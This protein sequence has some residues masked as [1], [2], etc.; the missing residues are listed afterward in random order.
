MSGLASVSTLTNSQRPSASRASFSTM[1][2]RKRQGPHHAAQRSTNTGTCALRAITCRSKSVTSKSTLASVVIT[3]LRGHP[4]R[5]DHTHRQVPQHGAVSG[6]APPDAGDR[7][8]L[9]AAVPKPPEITRQ[10]TQGDERGMDQPSFHP[11]KIR[12]RRA[13]KG[14]SGHMNGLLPLG[15]CP[16][17]CPSCCCCWSY[18][19]PGPR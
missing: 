5:K 15:P 10:G 3:R 19:T 2:P 18:P 8:T 7:A 9:R 4:P 12:R 11:T 1:G 6:A 17:P 14:D 13:G 16:A